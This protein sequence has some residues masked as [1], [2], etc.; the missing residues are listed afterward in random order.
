MIPVIPP[1]AMI[2]MFDIEHIKV[3]DTITCEEDMRFKL[4][5]IQLKDGKQWLVAF[6]SQAEFEKGAAVSTISNP[7]SETLKGCGNMPEEGIII[8]P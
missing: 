6:T 4:H 2:K 1:E 5:H 7:I 3:G 8:N